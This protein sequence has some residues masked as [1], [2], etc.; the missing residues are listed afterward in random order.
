MNKNEVKT[1]IKEFW[2]EHRTPIVAG[3]ALATGCLVGHKWTMF[4]M[5]VGMQVIC[6]AN[7]GLE[8]TLYDAIDNYNKTRS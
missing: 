1:K 4:K 2:H 6:A 8:K 3:A 7:P 5:N